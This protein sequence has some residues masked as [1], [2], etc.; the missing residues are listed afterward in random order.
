MAFEVTDL[1]LIL[2]RLVIDHD[3]PRQLHQ[4]ADA[5][6]CGVGQFLA[7]QDGGEGWDVYPQGSFRL[8]TV[9]RSL[10]VNYDLDMVCRRNLAVTTTKDELVKEIG[11]ALEDYVRQNLG[12]AGA[13]TAAEAGKRCW[14]LYY[15]DG[16][17]MDVLPAIPDPSGARNAIL[18]ADKTRRVWLSSNPKEF[19]RWFLTQ[20]LKQPGQRRALTA[21][22]R[23]SIEAVPPWGP[24]RPLQ[25]AVQV[26][27][28]HK[29]MYFLDQLDACPPSVLVTTLAGHVYDGSQD[30]VEAVVNIATAMA[31][32]VE[33]GPAGPVVMSPVADENFSEKWVGHPE[34]FEMFLAWLGAVERDL[35]QVQ[36]LRGLDR[37]IDRLSEAFGRE[38]ITK[39]AKSLGLETRT[40]RENGALS[41]AGAGFM[42]SNRPGATPVP[43]HGFYGDRTR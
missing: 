40:V 39:A 43:K 6:Y 18:L 19:G 31:G 5:Q 32:A 30:L 9:V 12:T 20:T 11:V 28:V 8:G 33:H 22:A 27:K 3:L 17:H 13:P 10:A 36:G 29:G 35:D 1:G 7:D 25:Q 37:V 15:D 14:T 26:L 2:Q 21:E 42:L 41:V 24:K 23:K 34:Y 16:F 38:P 4:A